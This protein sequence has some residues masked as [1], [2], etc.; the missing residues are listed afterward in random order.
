MNIKDLL[1][2]KLP[3]IILFAVSLFLIFSDFVLLQSIGKKEEVL[4]ASKRAGAESGTVRNRISVSSADNI[5]DVGAHI[6]KVKN[7]A[8]EIKKI[9]KAEKESGDNETGDEVIKSVDDITYNSIDNIKSLEE[10]DKRPAWK[11]F[12]LGPDYKNLGKIRSNLVQNR[13]QIR[14]IEKTIEKNKDEEDANTL[15]ARLG[16]LEQERLKIFNYIDEKDDGFSLFGW[17]TKL[18]FGYNKSIEEEED[19]GEEVEIGEDTDVSSDENKNDEE[20][21]NTEDTE[22]AE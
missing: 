17:L 9:A 18:M 11:N 21:K 5:P 22:L 19:L 8:L 2:I 7:S 16:E 3:F 13:N 6:S 12:L 4:G 10:I 20:P 15:R 14:K 1:K